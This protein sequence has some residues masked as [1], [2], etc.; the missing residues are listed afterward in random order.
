[1]GYYL[2]EANF[3]KERFVEVRKLVLLLPIL[4]LSLLL[5]SLLLSSSLSS[6]LLL[7]LSVAPKKMLFK[8]GQK[9]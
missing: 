6:L 7:P 3:N 8:C 9:P 2:E 1:M 5:L 4:L